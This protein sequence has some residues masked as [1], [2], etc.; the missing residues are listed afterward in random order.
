VASKSF[1][2]GLA[3]P[4]LQATLPDSAVKVGP[5][6][7]KRVEFGDSVVVDIGRF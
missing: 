4:S 1:P 5:V 7:M 3:E 2:D 6:G